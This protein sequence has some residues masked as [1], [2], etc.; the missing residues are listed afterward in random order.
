MKRYYH[1]GFGWDFCFPPFGFRFWGPWGGRTWARVFPRREDYLRMLKQYIGFP[2]DVPS[3]SA[4][5]AVKSN[6]IG[7]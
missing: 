6:K 2:I 3:Y 5:R 4:L 1:Y 7:H